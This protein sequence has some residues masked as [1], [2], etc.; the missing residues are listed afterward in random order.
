MSDVTFTSATAG[1]HG[2]SIAAGAR[3]FGAKAVIFIAAGVPEAFAD[4]LKDLGAE[5]IR[6]GA[7]YQGSLDAALEASEK[8]GWT[9]LSDTSWP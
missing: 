1:N 7:D 5:V 4:R 8:N 9:L 2:L 6:A 3:A